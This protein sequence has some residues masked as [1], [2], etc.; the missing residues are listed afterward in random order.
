M[1]RTMPFEAGQSGNPGGRPK[2]D[3]HLRILAR[4]HTEKAFNTLVALMD[5]EDPRVRL[6]AVGAVLDRGWGKPVQ[7][8]EHQ[9]ADG[10]AIRV[11]HI[12]RRIIDVRDTDATSL[13]APAE[14]STLSGSVG[15]EGV[16]QV[17]LLRRVVD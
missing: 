13:P 8:V 5:D 3:S 11:E 16:G 17:T 2:G 15:R 7:A 14:P 1:F 4:Q 10:D 9:G 12:L 6:G